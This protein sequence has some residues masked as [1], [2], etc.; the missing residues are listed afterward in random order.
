[1]K[2]DYMPFKYCIAIGLFL[3]N[4]Y[5]F[6]IHIILNFMISLRRSQNNFHIN[7]NFYYLH[8]NS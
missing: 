1:M 5:F 2:T 7:I 8:I 4:V 3:F 6:R